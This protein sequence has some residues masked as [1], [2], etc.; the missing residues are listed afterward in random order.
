MEQKNLVILCNK[1]GT[2][3][4]IITDEVS[5]KEKDCVGKKVTCMV[6]KESLDKAAGFLDSLANKNVALN[7]EMFIQTDQGKEMLIF[8][9]I[10]ID[11]K[12]LIF[13][14]DTNYIMNDLIEEMSRISNEQTNLIRKLTQEKVQMARLERERIERDLHD[15][16]SQTVFS[17]RLIAEILP[18]L[19]KKD[20]KE[21]KKQLE[22]LKILAE[23]SLTDMRR[24]LLELKPDSFE[25]ED[26][27]DL[28]GQIIKSARLRSNMDIKI[29]V[30]GEK[31]DLDARVK[32]ALYRIS[33]E[34]INNSIKH[35]GASKL[36]IELKFLPENLNLKIEDNGN[37][38]NTE[39]IDKNKYGLYIIK[40]R[41]KTI[42]AL[43][44]IKSNKGKGTKT[45]LT[46]KF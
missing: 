45:T 26:L 36:N 17:T 4:G 8:S 39:K 30:I 10:R 9:G 40:E 43:I 16:V 18:E 35:S 24:I 19:W 13:A 15:T 31:A 28:I 46:Y 3:T 41:A 11:E 22:N 7:Y 33:Q 27:E 1:Q 44:D 34:S 5:L 32:E 14:T 38:F 23:E 2:I 37:G 42:G 25:E 20:R 21:A 12:L 29:K 6:N